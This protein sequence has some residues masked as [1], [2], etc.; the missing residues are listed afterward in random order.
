M[1]VLLVVAVLVAA[2]VLGALVYLSIGPKSNQPETQRMDLSAGGGNYSA[3]GSQISLSVPAGALS[4]DL[5]ATVT[6]ASP[7][8][9]SYVPGTAFQFGPEGTSFAKPV[10]LRISYDPARV[11]DGAEGN[12]VLAKWQGGS[13]NAISASGVNATS[14]QVCGLTSSFSIFALIPMYGR[15]SIVGPDCLFPKPTFLDTGVHTGLNVTYL[16]QRPFPIFAYAETWSVPTDPWALGILGW[17][18]GLGQGGAKVKVMYINEAPV[19]YDYVT[20][21][22]H[23]DAPVD[24]FV[25]LT[26]EITFTFDFDVFHGHYYTW[27]TATKQI[28]VTY[29]RARIEPAKADCPPG[30]EVTLW[31]SITKTPP[32]F[33]CKWLWQLNSSSG[34]LWDFAYNPGVEGET[35]IWSS[36]AP[37]VTFRASDH[38][39]EGSVSR[40]LLTPMVYNPTGTGG[41]EGFGRPGTANITIKPPFVS[42]VFDTL[43]LIDLRRE[44]SAYF[45][46]QLMGAP[47]GDYVFVWNTTG[48]FGG[49]GNVWPASVTHMETDSYNQEYAGNGGGVDGERDVVTVSAYRIVG[50]GRELF[51]NASTTIEVYRPTV[52]YKLLD[53]D[54]NTS[55]MGSGSSWSTILVGHGPI[56]ATSGFYAR[57]NDTVRIYCEYKGYIPEWKH[58]NIYLYKGDIRGPMWIAWS[59][60]QDG[61]LKFEVITS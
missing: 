56:M 2:S 51:G 16:Q 41:Y 25:P 59:E 47:E 1:A 5:K 26:L 49:F 31:P 58:P 27:T 39:A 3:F 22:A 43:P 61:M 42:I 37:C 52:I 32:G 46:V 33:Q 7:S 44:L 28:E 15:A 13:W 57:V 53:Q 14:H 23:H 18:A 45:H 20:I 35:A 50:T 12:L 38:A 24:V 9:T 60:I 6:T 4:S 54:K 34:L 29:P 36:S 8:N 21:E 30:S 55:F 11:A 40:V 48:D 19:D 10:Q 17:R